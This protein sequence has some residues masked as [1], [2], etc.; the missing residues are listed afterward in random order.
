MNTE[1]IVYIPPG[2]GFEIRSNC[3]E[4]GKLYVL[5]AVNQK[6]CSRECKSIE[7]N[8]RKYMTNKKHRIEKLRQN[9]INT[10]KWHDRKVGCCVRCGRP[11]DQLCLGKKVCSDCISQIKKR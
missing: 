4:C 3:I 6:F 9:K 1:F 8:K 5:K 10:K 11:N 2:K 7:F